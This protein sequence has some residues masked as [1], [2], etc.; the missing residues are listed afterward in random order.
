MNL[1]NPQSSHIKLLY[2]SQVR[3]N[4]AFYPELS[5]PAES[6]PSLALGRDSEVGWRDGTLMAGEGTGSGVRQRWLWLE[7]A[8]SSLT[9]GGASY[10]IALGSLLTF[11]GWSPKYHLES[12]D[13]TDVDCHQPRPDDSTLMAAEGVVLCELVAAGWVAQG[14]VVGY[15]L[16]VVHFLIR[17]LTN[18][19]LQETERRWR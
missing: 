13:K 10:V 2:G 18:P 4:T 12:V 19:M 6:P 5:L 3:T 1:P 8:E 9:R 15:G 17:S 11:S 7:E 14:P 16:T